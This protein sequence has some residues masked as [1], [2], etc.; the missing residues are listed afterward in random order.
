MNAGVKIIAAA[1]ALLAAEC[2][3]RQKTGMAFYDA[4]AL[5]DSIPEARHDDSRPKCLSADQ[6]R[7]RTEAVAEMTDSLALPI[8]A[9]F[10][11]ENEQVVRDI[12]AAADCDYTFIH[13]TSNRFDGLDFALLY[14]SDRFTPQNIDTGLDYMYVTGVL[15]NMDIGLLICN[16]TRMLE[17]VIEEIRD[18]DPQRLLIVAGNI[19][20][21]DYSRFDLADAT[22]RAE[23]EGR[24]TC[25][26]RSGW[27]MRSR[28]YADTRLTVRADVYARSRFVRP[29]LEEPRRGSPYGRSL[30]V[31]AYIT[32]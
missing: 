11:V 23:A 27:Y 14:F 24:G 30:P 3:A 15:D 13:R 32:H 9:L 19:Y 29:L 7:R 6:Y 28:I 4:D 17:Y 12:A 31:F 2:F 1:A 5:Y 26:S 20:R 25:R 18:S 8:I 22:L 16:H 10:G 21:D